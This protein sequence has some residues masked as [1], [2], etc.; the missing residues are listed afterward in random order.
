VARP[1]IPKDFENRSL[2]EFIIGGKKKKRKRK[3]TLLH[4]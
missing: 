2:G 4:A 3:T 1:L